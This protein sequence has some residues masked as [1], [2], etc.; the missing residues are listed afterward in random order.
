MRS[1]PKE[2]RMFGPQEAA[3]S[4]R[5]W[6]SVRTGNQASGHRL[7]L[8]AI[9]RRD[10]NLILSRSL[11]TQ[12]VLRSGRVFGLGKQR[13]ELRGNRLAYI[14]AFGLRDIKRFPIDRPSTGPEPR[15]RGALLRAMPSRWRWPVARRLFS[16]FEPPHA[17]GS[18]P[19][20]TEPYFAAKS[21]S[22]I[23]S[24]AFAIGGRSKG[25]ASA[26]CRKRETG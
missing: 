9:R 6:A 15:G 10:E 2:R 14:I 16:R 1:T 3:N 5:D 21:W 18:H 25:P 17:S 24:I 19:R 26:S 11:P 22:A 23:L 20:A 7:L 12:I 8:S 13:R 4:D